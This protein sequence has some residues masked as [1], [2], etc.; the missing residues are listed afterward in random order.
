MSRIIRATDSFFELATVHS[1]YPV[2]PPPNNTPPPTPPP[3]FPNPHGRIN[4][5]RLLDPPNPTTYTSAMQ[6]TL[7]TPQPDNP[8]SLVPESGMGRKVGCRKGGKWAIPVP[9]GHQHPSR[10]PGSPSAVHL[11]ED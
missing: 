9:G 5:L 4:H 10:S 6:T 1:T 8:T 3:T 2:F 11:V 7:P